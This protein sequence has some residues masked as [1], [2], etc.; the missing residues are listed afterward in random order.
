M[1]LRREKSSLFFLGGGG[2]GEGGENLDT[3]LGLTEGLQYPKALPILQETSFFSPPTKSEKVGILG[4][5]SHHQPYFEKI[6]PDLRSRMGAIRSGQFAGQ[7]S[8]ARKI[9]SPSSFSP[10]RM[11]RLLLHT[12]CTSHPLQ[13]SSVLCICIYYIIFLQ[14]M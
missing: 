9:S 3:S 5:L 8:A 13:I 10:P 11:V 4:L 6:P 14:T 2:V 12:Y 1:Q 7:E